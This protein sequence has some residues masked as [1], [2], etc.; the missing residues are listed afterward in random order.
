[1]NNFNIFEVYG[2]VQLFSHTKRS[3][4]REDYPKEGGAVGGG[5]TWTAY[6]LKWKGAWGMESIVYNE[7]LILFYVHYILNL[8]G[9][10]KKIW[11]TLIF[12]CLIVK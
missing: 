10:K 7:S 5:R 4:A 1:M 2:K 8:I 9:N 6:R 12:W 3:I 11:L